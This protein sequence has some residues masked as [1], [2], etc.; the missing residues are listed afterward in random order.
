MHTNGA[1]VDVH[2]RTHE[3]QKYEK[4]IKT[5]TEKYQKH[6]RKCIKM[7]KKYQKNIKKRINDKRSIP[8]VFRVGSWPHCP[9]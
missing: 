6:T 5:N 8:E 1:R 4:R 2:T 3:K 7:S 9:H